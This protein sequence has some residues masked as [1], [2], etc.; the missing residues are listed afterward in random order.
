M[1]YIQHCFICRPSD[2]TVV[3]GLTKKKTNLENID[4]LVSISQSILASHLVG[5]ALLLERLLVVLEVAVA[6][7][8]RGIQRQHL[9]GQLQGST[10]TYRSQLCTGTYICAMRPNHN[11]PESTRLEIL[12]TSLGGGGA[13]VTGNTFYA[14]TERHDQTFALRNGRPGNIK[15]VGSTG[16]PEMGKHPDLMVGP[17]TPTV[18]PTNFERSQF[19]EKI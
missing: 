8:V 1:Y 7:R 14:F 5:G 2:S 3:G 6:P 12:P 11:E 17:P 19:F 16:I 15:N 10:T 18:F 4:C 9:P 13:S